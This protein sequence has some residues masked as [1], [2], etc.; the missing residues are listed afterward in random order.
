MTVIDDP[1]GLPKKKMKRKAK[2]AL[3]SSPRAISVPIKQSS[4]Q[5]PATSSTG[6][7]SI[8]QY[9]AQERP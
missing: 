5:Q 9:Q 8:I 4:K 2:A 1:L 3:S 6:E 7:R